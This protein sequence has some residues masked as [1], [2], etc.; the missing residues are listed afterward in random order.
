MF[1]EPRIWRIRRQRGTAIELVEREFEIILLLTFVTDSFF[2]PCDKYAVFRSLLVFCIFILTTPQPFRPARRADLFLFGKS[3][4]QF[5]ICNFCQ[6]IPSLKISK[7]KLL[8]ADRCSVVQQSFPIFH[9]IMDSDLPCT[10]YALQTP[11]VCANTSS[12]AVLLI[13][14][15]PLFG[16]TLLIFNITCKPKTSLLD[17]RRVH[18]LISPSPILANLSFTCLCTFYHRLVV[19]VRLYG[20]SFVKKYKEN[21]CAVAFF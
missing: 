12:N 2:L 10:Y 8:F 21:E 17:M 11:A 13:I 14:L 9:C 4:K 3:V 1:I 6:K 20:M 18:F 5:S 15:L 16:K 7:M 19:L